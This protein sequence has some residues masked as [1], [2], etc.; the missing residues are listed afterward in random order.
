MYRRGEIDY[1]G[2]S[3]LGLTSFPSFDTIALYLLAAGLALGVSIA[4]AGLAYYQWKSVLSNKSDIEE[5]IVKKA[6]MTR[7]GLELEI[8]A[9]EQSDG[10]QKVA[11]F[12]YP[13]DLGSAWKNFASMARVSW[14][15][16]AYK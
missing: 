14:G 6:N 1:D 15:A 16:D 8:A 11:P 2:V 5:W 4:V 13:Y 9:D 3:R 10:S 7:R 12:V